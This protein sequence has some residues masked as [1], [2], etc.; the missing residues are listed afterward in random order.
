[1]PASYAGSWKCVKQAG[2][3]DLYKS[4]NW[5]SCKGYVMM[6]HYGSDILIHTFYK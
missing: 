5:G 6:F 1:M 4:C 3:N 2:D